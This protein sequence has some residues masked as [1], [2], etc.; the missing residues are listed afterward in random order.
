MRVRPSVPA[1]AP[2][3][4][5]ASAPAVPPRS[6]WWHV[7][8]LVLLAAGIVLRVMVWAA[9][10]P[11]LL[12]VDS[13]RYLG[14]VDG[15]TVAGP[16]P[17]GY[18]FFLKIL[19]KFGDLSLVPIAQHLIG[20]GIGVAIY[21]FLLRRGV[22]PGLSALAAAPVLL[23]AY[24][25]Q[26]SQ[27]VMSDLL[28]IAVVVLAAGV[29]A[30]RP[31][32]SI[33]AVAV[34]GALIGG[35]VSVRGVGQAA[36]IAALLFVLVAGAGVRWRRRLA[37]AAVLLT[38][39]A[40]ALG[41]Y[42]AVCLYK[43]DEW[44]M[45]GSHS[46]RILY[47]RAA[48]FVDCSTI[49]LPAHLRPLCPQPPVDRRPGVD[50]YVWGQSS[51]ARHYRDPDELAEL[52]DFARQVYGQQPLDLAKATVVDFFRGFAPVKADMPKQVPIGRWQFQTTYPH[53]GGAT[54]TP[55]DINERFG[56]GPPVVDARI[57]TVLRAYQLGPGHVPGTVVG[58]CLLL[59]LLGAAGVGRAWRSPL[60]STAFLFAATGAGVLLI[61][62]VF[63]F[64]WRYQLPGV[65]I[66]PVAG[67]LGLTALLRRVPEGPEPDASAADRP[68]AERL[69]QVTDQ[70]RPVDEP[71]TAK[72]ARRRRRVLPFGEPSR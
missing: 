4:E 21:L 55:A 20:L 38:G 69:P 64:S 67:A 31:P 45:G 61:A 29:L 16:D 27:L 57:A 7:P 49:D 25:L 71:Q 12:Y 28:F 15:G 46:A 51:P 50:E 32:P 33:P 39:F 23:D 37:S 47:A 3:S 40:V 1:P 36:L 44:G 42:M 26:I 8:F 2:E 66:L 11:V 41:A 58:I 30:W 6:A 14:M 17:A 56:G 65:V 35:A 34:A 70:L 48:T 13:Y 22:H 54:G 72:A 10:R 68:D 52:A 59:G 18:A 63:Q 5:R 19:L 62:A 24:V 9:Y 60:R 53:H 43:Y